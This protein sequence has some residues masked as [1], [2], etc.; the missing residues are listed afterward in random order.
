MI[1]VTFRDSK[2]GRWISVQ[3]NTIDEA[4]SNLTAAMTYTDAIKEAVHERKA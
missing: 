4:M 2:D 3:G 1:E